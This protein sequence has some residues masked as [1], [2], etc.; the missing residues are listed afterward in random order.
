MQSE[1]HSNVVDKPASVPRYNLE[2]RNPLVGRTA[3]SERHHGDG[4]DARDD[5]LASAAG[6]QRLALAHFSFFLEGYCDQIGV[7][8]ATE[9]PYHGIPKHRSNKAAFEFWDKIG[10]FFTYMGRDARIQC[11]LKLPILVYQTATQY[12]SSVKVYYTNKFR[13][14]TPIPVFQA[15]NWKKLRLILRGTIAP[16]K[17]LEA[18]YQQIII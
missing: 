11:D 10:A 3:C 4:A 7:T 5:E 6:K 8:D 17:S 14:E 12:C 16:S 13:K 18:E 15:D 2:E 9:I 1:F